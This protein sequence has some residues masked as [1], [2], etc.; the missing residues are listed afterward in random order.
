MSASTKSGIDSHPRINVFRAWSDSQRH[1]ILARIES[2]LSEWHAAWG[3]EVDATDVQIEPADLLADSANETAII[4]IPSNG[5]PISSEATALDTIYEALFFA[6]SSVRLT[7][8]ATPS[9]AHDVVRKAWDDWI[10]R[11]ELAFGSL[12]I[13]EN[14]PVFLDSESTD[15]PASCSWSGDLRASLMWCGIRQY[16]FLPGAVINR[17]LQSFNLIQDSQNLGSNAPALSLLSDALNSQR[18][19]V[20][21]ELS[22]VSV[23]LGE[24]ESLSVGDVITLPHSLYNPLQLLGPQDQYL[25]GAWLGKKSGQVAVELVHQPKASVASYHSF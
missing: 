8:I 19:Q 18:I 3:F 13:V 24:I 15:L 2:T 9:I 23:S 11:L 7:N 4:W 25:C 20:R 5:K 16:L 6:K 14:D 1:W 22:Q 21:A 17:L 10:A 12:P